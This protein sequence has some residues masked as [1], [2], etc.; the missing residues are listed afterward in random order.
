MF[1]NNP[2]SFYI[3]Y[4][5]QYSI[6]KDY[7]KK[8]RNRVNELYWNLIEKND[9][10]VSQQS[11]QNI[12]FNNCFNGFQELQPNYEQN[13]VYL[14]F[15]DV[16][17]FINGE[18]GNQPKLEKNYHQNTILLKGVG[19]N[20]RKNKI[21]IFNSNNKIAL[22]INGKI[23]NWDD[24]FLLTGLYL[25]D[26]FYFLLNVMND[27]SFQIIIDH[28]LYYIVIEIKNNEISNFCFQSTNQYSSFSGILAMSPK[29]KT[30]TDHGNEKDISKLFQDYLI[31]INRCDQINPLECSFSKNN[32]FQSKLKIQ[33]IS[34]PI[35]K[36]GRNNQIN[37]LFEGRLFGSSG[38]S[39][40][41]QKFIQYVCFNVQFKCFLV[42]AREGGFKDQ[43][44]NNLLAN[45]K[46]IVN[47]NIDIAIWNEY[48][49]NFQSSFTKIP[50]VIIY[51]WEFGVISIQEIEYIRNQVTEVWVPSQYD[52]DSFVDSGAQAHKIIKI[53][54]GVDRN[55]FNQDVQT[56]KDFKTKKKFKLLFVG[57]DIPRKGV[58]VLIDSYLD[59]FTS[60]DDVCL[61]I[62]SLYSQKFQL[63][64]IQQL[65]AE[66]EEDRDKHPEI[67]LFT[68]WRNL[69]DLI[70][71][72]R[73]VDYVVHPFRSEGFGLTMLEAMSIG[74]PIIISNAPPAT[75]FTDE[76]NAIYIDAT[77]EYCFDPP[78]GEKSV[79]GMDTK[80]QPWWYEP[81]KAHLTQ[82]MKNVYIN[83]NN[84]SQKRIINGINQAKKT[85]WDN[86]GIN[87][88]NRIFE[89]FKMGNR[90]NYI[91]IDG[92]ETDEEQ[93]KSFLK[94]KVQHFFR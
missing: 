5:D 53:F 23:R 47:E 84:L 2:N 17:L 58:D 90:K 78:C 44:W 61:I 54:H 9:Y 92:V 4:F 83:R 3:S 64:R 1:E 71:I 88:R 21:Q 87:L 59:A 51:P 34:K 60:K 27:N 57:G 91:I 56:Y 94:Y 13:D 31:N 45:K 14:L 7:H 41:S 68:V 69:H 72:Y 15:A 40:V 52:V 55:I 32:Y 73:S 77:R 25:F 42:P 33:E 70:S 85:S 8:S 11:S 81:N 50:Y 46:N 38:Y 43:K 20:T 30:E 65:I 26:D 35:P 36:T 29:A 12:I 63:Q 62:I 49:V 76:T 67:E 74:T 24:N 75:E 37:I 48:P 66:N 28:H 93:S 10:S 19:I 79:F 82:I 16:N 39:A 18:I 86:V 22:K 6:C 80:E 89:L